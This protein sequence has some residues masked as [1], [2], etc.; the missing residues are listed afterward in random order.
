[1]DL[2][3]PE[4]K[5]AANPNT[6]GPLN[7]SPGSDASGQPGAWVMFD[8]DAQPTFVA[9]KHWVGVDLD[10]TLSRTDNVGHFSPPYPLGDPIPDMIAMV[11]SLLQAG[12]T[13]KIFSARACE[14]DSIPI[15]QAWTEKHGLGRLQVTNQKDFDLIRFYDDRA[16]QVLPNQG[17]AVA[18]IAAR[19]APALSA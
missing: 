9:K 12:V 11:K 15:V 8:P 4:L 14:A 6:M 17:K 7:I 1:L 5:V 13:V 3:R 19:K 2:P 10:G 16:I 18:W